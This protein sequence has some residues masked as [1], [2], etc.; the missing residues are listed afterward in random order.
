MIDGWTQE[1][2]TRLELPLS[3]VP[4][5]QRLAGIPRTGAKTLGTFGNTN[6][7]VW[8]MSPG[9]MSDVEVDEIFVVLHGAA[10]VE[11]RDRPMLK[12][13]PTTRSLAR[14][15][16]AP[17]SKPTTKQF[18]L[19]RRPSTF[20]AANQSPFEMYVIVLRFQIRW[21]LQRCPSA[22]PTAP[23]ATTPTQALVV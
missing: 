11:F 9:T 23:C 15:P 22:T 10:T 4:A 3:D 8:E 13:S 17:L 6:I 18:I 21:I 12:L 16:A 14:P 2:A 20:R 1:A 5:A 7:G 19:L